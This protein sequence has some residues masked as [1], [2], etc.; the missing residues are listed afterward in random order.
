LAQISLRSAR[1]RP[2][3]PVDQR[4]TETVFELRDDHATGL[5]TLHA[6]DRLDELWAIGAAAG[7]V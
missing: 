5:P 4:A 2:R 6:L 3:E 7:L 1:V